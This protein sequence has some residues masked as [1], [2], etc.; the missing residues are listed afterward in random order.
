MECPCL[1]PHASKVTA[2]EDTGPHCGAGQPTLRHLHKH[3]HSDNPSPPPGGQVDT[4]K[5]S[6]EEQRP[7]QDIFVGPSGARVAWENTVSLLTCLHPAF[8]L[9]S[10]LC[11]HG[12]VKLTVSRGGH[13]KRIRKAETTMGYSEPS[14][15]HWFGVSLGIQEIGTLDGMQPT[16]PVGR[17]DWG[18]PSSF[19]NHLPRCA[20]VTPVSSCIASVWSPRL[21]SCTHW[22]LS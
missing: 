15:V 11:G 22:A 18:I 10:C 9:S 14:L 13:A 4:L 12:A 5:G 21:F 16:H 17:G 19:P 7:E 20:L 1:G 6:G 8:C 3:L 2:L